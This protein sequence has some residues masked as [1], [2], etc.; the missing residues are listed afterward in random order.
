[1]PDAHFSIQHLGFVIPD[2]PLVIP[3][4]PLV[5][6][7][8]PFVIPDSIRDPVLRRHWIA[9]RA[10]NDKGKGNDKDKGNDKGKGNDRQGNSS[11][12]CNFYVPW[13]LINP[14]TTCPE[15]TCMEALAT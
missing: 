9:G 1:M 14:L 5:I 10:R 15:G 6:P 3:D 7:D 12:V 4:S 2:S 11:C 13:L 8:S